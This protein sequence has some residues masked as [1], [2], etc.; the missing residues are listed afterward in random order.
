HIVFGT[1]HSPNGANSR[2]FLAQRPVGITQKQLISAHLPEGIRGNMPH[3]RPTKPL[4]ANNKFKPLTAFRNAIQDLI[5][6]FAPPSG[7]QQSKCSAGPSLATPQQSDQDVVNTAIDMFQE[8][9]ATSLPMEELIVG[10]SVLE[11]PSKAKM[12]L[13]IDTNY[14]AKWMQYEI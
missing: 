12:F 3:T 2:S 10:F 7:S 4:F 6:A 13:R 1:N 5:A 9:V 11:N 8:S 14:R